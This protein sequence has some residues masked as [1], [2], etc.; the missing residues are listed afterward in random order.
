MKLCQ[1]GLDFLFIFLVRKQK[2]K[3]NPFLPHVKSNLQHTIRDVSYIT[4]IT[5]FTSLHFGAPGQGWNIT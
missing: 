1:Q 3:Q 4:S 2:V 5:R